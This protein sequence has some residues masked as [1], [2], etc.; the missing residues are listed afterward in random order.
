MN[1]VVLLGDSI[2]DN[3][4]YVSGGPAVIEY[5]H[6]TLPAGWRATLLAR[7]GAVTEGVLRQLEQLPDDATHLVISAGGCDALDHSDVFLHEKASSFGEVLSQLAGIH[8]LFRHDYHQLMEAVVAC[9]RPAAVCTVYD[10]IPGLDRVEQIG[11]YLFN[12]V[13]LREAIR[14]AL[15]VLDLR[16]VCTDPTDYSATSP[17]EPSELGGRKIASA[18]SRLVT[19]HD[20]TSGCRVVV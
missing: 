2:F 15:P 17:I 5:L 8:E 20:F 18:I 6:R 4:R 13:I 10:A 7:D 3:A 12:D 11:L 16:L 14:G 1:H 9:G 19:K